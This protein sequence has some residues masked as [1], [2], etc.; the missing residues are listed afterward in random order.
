MQAIAHA[1]A[2][3][4]TAILL[5]PEISLTPQTMDRFRARFGEEV[6][7]LHSRLSPG[8]RYDEWRRLRLGRARVAI[9][10]RSAVFAPLENIKLIVVDE[11]HE[12]SY[13]SE[14]TPR[15]SAIEVAERRCRMGGGVLLLGSATPSMASYYRA[16]RGRYALLELLE[17]VKGLPMPRVETAD[18]RNEFAAGNT[19][20]FSGQLHSALKDCIAAGEQAMLFVNR[21]G[22]ST[23]VSCRGCGYVFKCPSCDVSLTYH[24]L[25]NTLKCHYCGGSHP[26]PRLC[27][28]CR[29]PY[30]KFFGVGTQQVE[31]Q[32]QQAFP[33]VTSLRMDAD[34][35]R[36]KNAHYE[37]LNSFARGEAQVLIGTQ[38]IAKGLDMPGVSLV[39][40]VAADASLHIPDY[41]SCE[42]TFQ[43]ITQVAGRAGRAQGNG[44][45][46]VQTYTPE[47]PAIAMASRHDYKGFYEYEAAQRRQALFPPFGLFLRVLFCHSEEG[48]LK[49]AAERFAKGLREAVEEALCAQGA[50]RELIFMVCSE[51]PIRRKQ[52]LYRYHVLAKLVRTAHTPKA[53]QAAYAYANDH[54][55]EYFSSIELNPTDMF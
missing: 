35:T 52:G 25:D 7:V 40:V 10:A 13:F 54:R 47:H 5:V 49:E 16:Q 27:P 45:V 34:T 4:G 12:Q 51:A 15:Y 6:A 29:R 46:I 36:G 55:S 23:F 18:M 11:E 9:G 43:L 24:K 20:V 2:Q 53:V 39:G 50:G 30:I 14:H 26:I 28:D 44:R 31:E 33:G 17:R 38:M 32:L 48:P 21:R 41:R 37:L 22:Y 3:G 8:E 19:G 1:L 42:R